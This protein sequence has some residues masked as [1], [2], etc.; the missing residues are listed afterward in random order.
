[1]P[2]RKGLL[3]WAMVLLLALAMALACSDDD[4]ETPTN[5][6]TNPPTITSIG[7]LGG[8]LQI[9]GQVVL[10]IA[11]GALADTVEFSVQQNLS[12]AAL[13]DG[14]FA[15]NVY[16]IGPSGTQFSIPAPLT[17]T[18]SETKLGK[19]FDTSLQIFT[20]DGS[21][22]DSL[23]TVL[24]SASHLAVT[25]VSHLSDF[26]V[27]ADTGG[28]S[29]GNDIVFT[30][31]LVA[32]RMIMGIEGEEE[33]YKYDEIV[34]RF[35]SSLTPCTIV[36]PQQADSVHCNQYDI[37]WNAMVNAHTY[38]ASQ[39]MPFLVLDTD[40]G[41]TVFGNAAVPS[42]T[43]T[44]TFP[45]LEPYLTSPAIGA[46]VSRYSDLVLTWA[47]SGAGTVGIFMGPSQDGAVTDTAF[48]IEVPNT[49]NYTI[50][51]SQMGIFSPGEF[52]IVM[53]H[54]NREA[55]TAPG[56]NSETSF[57]AG[58]IINATWVTLQ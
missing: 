52:G 50:T 49:G 6:G 16:T 45:S 21:G 12:P 9:S 3:L 22:W 19:P 13:P 28:T 8:V 2:L 5:G 55:I 56:Y 17:I 18:F 25:T 1:M 23:T 27:C 39:G 33:P 15:S 41:F 35:D 34:A 48:S 43:A 31:A 32:A 37:T 24:D 53:I 58:R 11:P 20:N 7:P 54:Q 42:L 44:I 38:T 26:A 40:Y 4:E 14:F 47:D 51:P 30:A 36:N 29:S 46:T 57:I 10:T